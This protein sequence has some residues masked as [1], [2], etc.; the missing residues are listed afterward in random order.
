M[1]QKTGN[2]SSITGAHIEGLIS[3][4]IAVLT[5]FVW[6]SFIGILIRVMEIQIWRNRKKTKQKQTHKYREQTDGGQMGA[7]VEGLGEKGE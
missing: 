7:G 4:P 6:I 2:Y 5:T 1:E 3:S